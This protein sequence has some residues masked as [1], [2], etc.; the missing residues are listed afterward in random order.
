MSRSLP[1]RPSLEQLR[2]QAKDLR[3]AQRQGDASVCP[4]LRRLARFATAADDDILTAKLSIS[5]AQHALAREYGHKSWPALVRAVKDEARVPDIYLSDHVRWSEFL[6][7][8]N[9]A[10][11]AWS[12]AV[13][14]AL[15]EKPA[16]IHDTEN[17]RGKLLTRHFCQ[18]HASGNVRVPAPRRRSSP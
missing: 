17:V 7:T 5:E 16:V 13:K 2:K 9:P 11:G 12:P 15:C 10:T 1:P 8:G 3:K 14:C 18:D 4:I 6:R